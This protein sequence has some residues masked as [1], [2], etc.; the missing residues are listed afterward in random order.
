M[1]RLHLFVVGI[2]EEGGE[3]FP[4]WRV[5][6]LA[7]ALHAKRA[8]LCPI[9][10]KFSMHL[11]DV[12]ASLVERRRGFS[13]LGVQQRSTSRGEFFIGASSLFLKVSRR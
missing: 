10:G 6:I 9:I 12:S 7:D 8:R 4:A 3:R 11:I 1:E 2:S 5:G 13:G